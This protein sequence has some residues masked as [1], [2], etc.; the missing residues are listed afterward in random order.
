M[1]TSE[2]LASKGGRVV[3]VSEDTTVL[4]AAEM[5]ARE[6]VVALVVGDAGQPLAGIMSERDIVRNMAECG[7]AALEV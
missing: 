3:A 2:T 4:Q 7:S 5:L 1:Q 6:R